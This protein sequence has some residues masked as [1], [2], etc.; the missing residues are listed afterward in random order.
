MSRHNV[1]LSKEY[2]GLVVGGTGGLPKNRMIEDTDHR[3][4]LKTRANIQ[5]KR[6][7]AEPYLPD[8]ILVTNVN[9][10]IALGRPLLL[11]G[12]P[13]CGKTRL[14]Y[15]VAYEFGMP[16]EECYIKSTSRAQDLLYTYDAINRLYD[17]Q[18]T[19][20]GKQKNSRARDIREY[21]L[22]GPLG[23]AIARAQY[24][25]RSVVLIDEIDKADLDFP[26]DLLFE[27]DR[28]AFQVA[29]APDMRY[30]VPEN[31]PDLRPIVIVT[32]NEEK[33]LPAAFLRRCIYHYLSLPKDREMELF[34]LNALRMHKMEDE[35]LNVR[36]VQTYQKLLPLGLEKK[37]GISELLDW[38]GYMTVQKQR[39]QDPQPE[40]LPNVGALIKGQSDLH[41]VRKESGL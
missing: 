35:A 27:L 17:V 37:P 31:R 6:I 33:A 30:A 12:E 3:I 14:A 38:V 41:R 26:N 15:A 5:K 21:I 7:E 2:K 8:P 9:L 25:R 16:L 34:L 10:A 1:D 11:Q 19:V 39:G 22:L 40:E 32:H 18:A 29:E 24:G 13:G 4:P 23:R 28:L 36:A 20:P